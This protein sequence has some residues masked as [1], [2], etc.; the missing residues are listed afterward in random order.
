M[1]EM[2]INLLFPGSQLVPNVWGACREVLEG[3]SLVAPPS[4][5]ASWPASLVEWV[6]PVPG[7]SGQ[8]ES[9]KTPTKPSNPGAGKLTPGSGKKTQP[10]QQAAGMFW[11]DKKKNRKRKQTLRLKRRSVGRN[12]PG[13]FLDEHEHSITELTN[14]AA[15]SRPAQ[16]S[17]KTPSS[18][19]K[20][21]V[22]PRKDPKAVPD[23]SDD[24]PLSDQT[25]E[26]KAKAR[27]R[28]PTPDLV[29]VDDDDSTPLPRRQK[30]PKKSVPVEE[31]AT[32]ALVQCKA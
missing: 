1:D 20:D 32:E 5:L 21:W 8:S 3:L 13:L 16:P 18:A 28:D 25:N 27:K 17:G 7:T 30:T 15:P 6:T 31:E 2:A 26:P 19:S 14:R 10:I 24:E 9:S 22:R 4:C 29:V 11:G 23:P 12:P